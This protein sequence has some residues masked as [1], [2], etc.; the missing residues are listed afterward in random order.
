[1]PYPRLWNWSCS[2]TWTS[3]VSVSTVRRLFGAEHF[4]QPHPLAGPEPHGRPGTDRGRRRGAR[5]PGRRWAPTSERGR[6]A[7]G[8]LLAARLV[9]SSLNGPIDCASHFFDSPFE[10]RKVLL[11]PRE[12]EEHL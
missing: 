8:L 3:P 6:G 7:A 5:A 12:F 9:N 4:T 10:G 1:M 2:T 11:Y